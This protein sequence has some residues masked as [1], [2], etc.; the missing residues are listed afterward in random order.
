MAGDD[1]RAG[2]EAATPAHSAEF[3]EF[4]DATARLAFGLAFRITGERAMS[5]RACEAA[6]LAYWKSRPGK[7][8]A[9]RNLLAEVRE[10]ALQVRQEAGKTV[11]DPRAYLIPGAVQAAIESLAAAERRAL[12]L[13]YFGGLRVDEAAELL[14]QPPAETRKAL[15][16]ALLTIGRALPT[17]GQR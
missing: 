6:Y 12:D 11:S 4:Y 2:A 16:T 3:A 5:E 1:A 9:E 14:G 8:V 17:G 15:R 7:L 13:V 10:Q